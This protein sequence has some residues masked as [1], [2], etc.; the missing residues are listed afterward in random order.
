MDVINEYHYSEH[1]FYTGRF[2]ILVIADVDMLKQITVKEFDSFMD[3]RLVCIYVA[4]NKSN[5]V[6]TLSNTGAEL[7]MHFHVYIQMALGPP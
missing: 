7:M 1:S 6:N 3:R 5:C 4:A 2:P